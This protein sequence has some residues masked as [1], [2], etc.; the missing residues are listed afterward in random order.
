MSG[1]S[2]CALRYEILRQRKV[3][4]EAMLTEAFKTP[5]QT[6]TSTAQL[7]TKLS[8][9]IF[10]SDANATLLPSFSWAELCATEWRQ[11]KSYACHL[12]C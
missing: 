10:A 9:F 12:P 4:L 7:K 1:S 11:C 6:F 3:Q 2:F 5:R 8:L